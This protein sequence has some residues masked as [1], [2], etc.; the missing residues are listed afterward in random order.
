MGRVPI[1]LLVVSVLVI[2]GGGCATVS[3]S[4][5]QEGAQE[6]IT[7]TLDLQDKSLIFGMGLSNTGNKEQDYMIARDR[8]LEDLSSQLV[9]S[10]VS[11][12][13]VE[14][15]EVDGEFYNRIQEQLSTTVNQENIEGVQ[16]HPYSYSPHEGYLVYAAI[17]KSA[18]DERRKRDLE[19]LETGVLQV[20]RSA[21]KAKTIVDEFSLLIEAERLLESSPY[22]GLATGEVFGKNAHLK[23][24]IQQRMLSLY[25]SMH[26]YVTG[27]DEV[28]PFDDYEV[29]MNVEIDM[30]HLGESGPLRKSIVGMPLVFSVVENQEVIFKQSYTILRGSDEMTA[31]QLP[32]SAKSQGVREVKGDIDWGAMGIDPTSLGY[33]HVFSRTFRTLPMRLYYKPV[34]DDLKNPIGKI[35]TRLAQSLGASIVSDEDEAD[36]IL[37]IGLDCSRFPESEGSA[38]RFVGT[39]LIV[40]LY[41]GSIPIVTL[42]SDVIK[43][44]GLSYEQAQSTAIEKVLDLMNK[45]GD[46]IG[47]ITS[48]LHTGM[49]N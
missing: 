5:S 48:V 17:A 33:T 38:L 22:S 8:A 44:G 41:R 23:S 25:Q 34:L 39:R 40:T 15:V 28:T 36:C 37:E 18:W 4:H 27:P 47:K 7:P 30:S 32:I 45:D 10:I 43:G 16:L 35:S 20:L 31:L 26:W 19:A 11:N 14:S 49:K 24:I 1:L 2:A 3:E 6:V 21:E 29:A 42:E 9:V 12:Y 46:L 13:S